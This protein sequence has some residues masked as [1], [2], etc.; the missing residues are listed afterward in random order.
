MGDGEAV[1]FQHGLDQPA[2]GRVVIDDE[3]GLGHA[4]LPGT[5]GQGCAR[6]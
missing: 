2:L 1:P 4:L 3:D 5:G 6:P